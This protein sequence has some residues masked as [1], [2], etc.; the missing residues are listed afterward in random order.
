MATSPRC[1]YNPLQTGE[2]LR[3]KKDPE[4]KYRQGV[5]FDQQLAWDVFGNYIQASRI[6]GV[7]PEYRKKVIEMRG[8]L[9]GPQIGSW[10]QLQE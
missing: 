5:S 7:D 8:K 2:V 6:L 10:G 1:R 3:P 4:G 9:L